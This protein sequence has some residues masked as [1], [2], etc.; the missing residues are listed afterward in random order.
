M[1]PGTGEA[2]GLAAPPRAHGFVA[3]LWARLRHLELV[4]AVPLLCLLVLV[5]VRTGLGTDVATVP[6][7]PKAVAEARTKENGGRTASRLLPAPP[8]RARYQP[9]TPLSCTRPDAVSDASVSRCEVEADVVRLKSLQET[10]WRPKRQGE[11]DH[12]E[13]TLRRFDDA[14]ARAR[15]GD[16]LV[17]RNNAS[18]NVT[19]ANEP[20]M[21]PASSQPRAAKYAFA[22]VS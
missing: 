19:A 5:S 4:H 13:A 3:R 9:G 22:M 15:G 7:S 17:R 16:T 6:V 18:N 11:L 20:Q 1:L 2:R 14:A 8:R 10:R 21:P 12:A